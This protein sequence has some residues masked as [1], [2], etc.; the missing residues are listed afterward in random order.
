MKGY[1]ANWSTIAAEIK[2]KANWHCEHCHHPHDVPAGY[3]LTVHHLNGLKSDC[4]F[5]NLVALCQRCH[6]RIQA[7]YHP[8]QLWLIC[9]PVWAEI[10]GL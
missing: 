2:D 5:Q 8:K 1:P 7:K 9:K 6:L 4:R 10:R 3:M